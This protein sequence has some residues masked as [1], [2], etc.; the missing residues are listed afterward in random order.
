M[1]KEGTLFV[2]LPASTPRYEMED[3]E[4]RRDGVQNSYG[5]FIGETFW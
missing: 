2:R 5:N 1:S 4:G 3:R